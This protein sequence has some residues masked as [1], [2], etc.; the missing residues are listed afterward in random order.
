LAS[1][2]WLLANLNADTLSKARSQLPKA[3]KYSTRREVILNNDLNEINKPP[4]G[5]NATRQKPEANSRKPK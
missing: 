1:G 4:T 5:L 3:N 2:Y